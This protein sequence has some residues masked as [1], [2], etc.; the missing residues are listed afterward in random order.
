VKVLIRAEQTG[1][2]EAIS[3][4]HIRAFGGTAEAAVVESLRGQGALLA[5]LVAVVQDRIVGHVG[6][7]PVEVGGVE[8][9]AV[10]LGPLAVDPDLQ[11][12]GIGVM[13]VDAF[14]QH[15]RVRDEG[16]VVVLGYPDYYARF[17]F[18]PAE[19]FGLYYHDAGEAFQALEVRSGAAAG[20]SGEVHYH[21]AFENA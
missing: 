10:A 20:L 3:E 7:S 9:A 6:L 17:G 12:R 19:R 8:R 1:E 11:G 18:V 15:C 16:L 4:V 2:D 21:P 14:L 13:L 5:S